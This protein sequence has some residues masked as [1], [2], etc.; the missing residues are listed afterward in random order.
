VPTIEQDEFKNILIIK[1]SAVGDIVCALPILPAL[2]RRYKSARIS[3]LVAAHLSDLLKDHPL[4]DE[5]IEFDRRRFGYLAHSW[6]VTKRFMKFLQQLRSARY[7]LVLD[8]QG[9][10]RSGFLA[11]TTQASVRIGPAEKRELG[12]V[13]YTHRCPPRPVDTHIVDR[14]CATGELM[15][16]DIS[17][18]KF[19][20]PVRQEA[21]DRMTE[22]LKAKLGESQRYLAVAPGATW[23][24]KRWSGESFARLT[25]MIIN[26]LDMS[27]AIVGGRADRLLAEEIINQVSNNRAISLAG[28]TRLSEL[29]AVLDGAVGLVSNDSGPMHMA[30]ALG[31]PVTAIIAPTNPYRTGPYR[32]P[33]ALVT[34]DIECAPCYK[35][36]CTKVAPGEQSA[37]MAAITAEQVFENLTRQ[38]ASD[39][40]RES[41]MSV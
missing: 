40:H 5:L 12:W 33:E 23:S 32:R 13:F 38:L 17:E 6:A 8:L 25:R 34:S 18:P 14:I 37:C 41:R 9:L 19:V 35:R 10:F 29:L 22:T 20:L 2:R 11:W 16:I 4:I 36:Q 21:R 26:E 39:R 1:P 7:D 15:G 28:Q 27:V 31:K 30:V 24:S 3:W